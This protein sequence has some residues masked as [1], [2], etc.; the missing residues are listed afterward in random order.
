MEYY[1]FEQTRG[2]RI[3]LFVDSS[4]RTGISVGK[5]TDAQHCRTCPLVFREDVMLIHG[6][7]GARI[8]LLSDT[9]GRGWQKGAR[10]RFRI[11]RI[12]GN[13]KEISYYTT[14]SPRIHMVSRTF[15]CIP[16]RQTLSLEDRPPRSQ[17]HL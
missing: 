4:C 17:V 16:L 10:H 2:C 13:T 14:R 12:D 6:C 7:I 11:S 8:R 1:N 5:E 15:S 9:V 3:R